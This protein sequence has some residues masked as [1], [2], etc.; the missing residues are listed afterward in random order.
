M[1]EEDAA[2]VDVSIVIVSW[3]SARWIGGCVASLRAAAGSLEW[4]AFVW[5]NASSDASA[6]IARDQAGRGVE[7]IASPLNRGFAGAINDLLPRLRGRHVFLLNPDCDPAPGSIEL[8]SRELDR[9]GSAGVVPLLVSRDGVPQRDFQLRRF[10]TLR[11]ILAETLLMD[12]VH[13]GNRASSHYR[14]RDLDITTPQ[15][16]EQPAA[17]ALM[18]DRKVMDRIG[19]LD[20]QFAPAWFEDV[21]YC[22]RIFAAGESLTLIPEARVIHFG[23]SS[24]E[25]L[26]FDRFLPL[27]YRNLF[28]YS[29]KWLGKGRS[30]AVRWAIVV[31]MLL[32]IGAV[33]LGIRTEQVSRDASLRGYREVLRM[34]W[35]RWDAK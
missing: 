12:R 10:P 17:A 22:R 21:D 28:R 6:N 26:G 14:Y 29:R 16:I 8:L 9:R 20:E 27:W 11:S 1:K 15:A 23:G 5:D 18:L 30:E 33:K 19:L 13:P 31:G 35:R 24:V 2:D 25:T 32:R 3:N 34:A 7:I 4:E